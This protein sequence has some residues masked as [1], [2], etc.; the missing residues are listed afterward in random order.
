MKNILILG[1]IG[2]MGEYLV[3][4]FVEKNYRVCVIICLFC[5]LFDCIEY[6]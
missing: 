4:M 2:V 1:G 5:W 6:I 3:N